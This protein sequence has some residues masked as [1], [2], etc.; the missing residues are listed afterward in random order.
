MR[1]LISRSF[2]LSSLA[3]FA[4]LAGCGDSTPTPTP[5]PM[6]DATPDSPAS[7]DA[8]ED[9]TV[10]PTDASSGDAAVPTDTARTDA[11]PAVDSA[12]MG[13][14]GF[15]DPAVRQHVTAMQTMGWA[16]LNRG[17]NMMMYGCTGTGKIGRAHV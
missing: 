11:L 9:T 15:I 17:R 1:T 5:N 14:C 4:T 12:P 3:V 6:A 7:S 10:P 2:V 13:E 16:A 8:A